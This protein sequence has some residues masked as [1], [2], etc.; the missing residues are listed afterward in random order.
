MSAA[1]DLRAPLPL[2]ERVT[3]ANVHGVD[4]VSGVL[5][6]DGERY[7]LE[8]TEAHGV[9]WIELVSVGSEHAIARAIVNVEG[10]R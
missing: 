7:W 5:A 1:I 6:F 10:A 9:P 3:L 2:G 4:R 8:G